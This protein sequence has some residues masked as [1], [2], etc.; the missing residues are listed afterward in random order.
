MGESKTKL[1]KEQLAFLD[2]EFHK[3]GVK[4]EKRK[5][6]TGHLILSFVVNGVAKSLTIGGSIDRNARLR[7]RTMLRGML[8]GR[9]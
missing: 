5:A 1:L 8:E 7:N 2:V 6:Y 3:H 9:A 4:Y